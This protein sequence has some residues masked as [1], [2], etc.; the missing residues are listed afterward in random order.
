MCIYPTENS[1]CNLLQAG[2][3]RWPCIREHLVFR[4]TYVNIYTLTIFRKAHVTLDVAGWI[5]QLVVDKNFRRRYIA[6][7]LLQTLKDHDLF[8]N[9]TVVGLASSHPAAC[10]ALAKYAG[11]S[12]YNRIS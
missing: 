9:V 4:R 6:T 12:L 5:T 2:G 11:K 10:N 3:T 1:P 7:H 8:Q